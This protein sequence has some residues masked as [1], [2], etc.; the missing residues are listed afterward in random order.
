MF[1]ARDGPLYHDR[2]LLGGMAMKHTCDRREVLRWAAWGAA[3]SALPAAGADEPARPRG[4]VEGHPVAA[5]VG[6]QVLAD[7]G[8]AV[9]AI[10]AAALAVGVVAPHQC[11]PGGYG[12]HAT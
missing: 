12:G 2:G 1:G 8:N 11:G 7:G 9:D 6:G 4:R 5:E 3:A 10:V